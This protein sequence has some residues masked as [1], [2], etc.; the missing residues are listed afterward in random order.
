[1]GRELH[2][3][4]RLEIEMS[5][6]IETNA[7]KSIS[8]DLRS[9]E[10]GSEC[11]IMEGHEAGPPS[12]EDESVQMRAARKIMGEYADTLRMLADS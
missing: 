1:M 10:T 4:N 9:E 2:A 3:R 5:E 11:Q 12:A 6:E 8:T 7:A